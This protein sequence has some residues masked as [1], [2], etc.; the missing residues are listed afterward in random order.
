MKFHKRSRKRKQIRNAAILG[1]AMLATFAGAYAYRTLFAR[2]GEA[3]LQLIPSDAILVVSVDISPSPTQALAFKHI[4]DALARNGQERFMEQALMS[5]LGKDKLMEEIV[6]LV[7]RGGALCIEPKEGK[8]TGNTAVGL[9][10]LSD[11]AKALESLKKYTRPSYFRGAKYY[12]A[13]G[14]TLNLM[15]VDDYLVVSDSPQ[16]L[17]KIK[18]VRQGLMKS[19]TSIPEF[20]TARDEVASDANMLVFASSNMWKELVKDTV[21]A[22]PNWVALGVALR[23]GGIGI[24]LAGKTDFEKFPALKAVANTPGVRNDLFKVLPAGS[25]GM[26]AV[27]DPSAMYQAS[28]NSVSSKGD[29]KKN[30]KEAENSLDKSIGLSVTGDIV[31]ALSGDSVIALYPSSASTAGVDGLIVID[32]Q[33]GASP[34]S[35]IQKFKEFMDNQVAKEH[36]GE[37]PFRTKSIEG[38]TEY[39]I[40]EK[41][42]E[43]MRKSIGNGMDPKDIDKDVL[44]SKKTV[45]VATIGKVV[46]ASTSQELLDRAIVSYRE[47]KN[48]LSMDSNYSPYEKTLLDGSQMMAVFSVSRIAEGI[49]NTARLGHMEPEAAKLFTSVLTALQTLKEPLYLK[50]KSAQNGLSTS[51]IFIPMDYDKLID[52]VGGQL[53][54]K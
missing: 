2:P 45:V 6:P 3:A 18:E 7:K 24:S 54:K 36:N 49:Q 51:G 14:S 17:L 15:V 9:I 50:G 31:P 37:M 1:V 29:A 21:D 28:V 46:L 4:D 19:I 34:S 5:G 26:F 35:A 8:N 10:A 30:I 48:A 11:G 20:N 53:K 22:S 27:S 13:P 41:M 43:D 47:T 25:Y 33:N 39:Q 32:D 40:T 42:E 38:G 23:D 12:T 44:V 52:I 16:E